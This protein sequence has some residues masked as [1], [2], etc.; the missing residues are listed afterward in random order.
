MNRIITI[1]SHKGGVGKTTTALNLAYAI[2]RFGFRTLLVDL[3]PESGTTIASNLRNFTSKGLIDLLL[4]TAVK[5]DV[6]AESNDKLLTV[7]GSGEILPAH[8]HAFEQAA[9]D[10]KLATL[11]KELGSDYQYTIIDAPAGVGGVVHAAL[12]ASQGAILTTNCSPISLKSIPSF[13]KLI[14]HIS[15]NGNPQLQLDGVLLSMVDTR[16]ATDMAIFEQIQAVIPFE[17]FFQTV[18]PYVESIAQ[19]S[20]EAVPVAMLPGAEEAAQLYT[21]LVSELYQRVNT[22]E[23]HGPAKLF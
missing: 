4:G 16:S 17:A 23:T 20:L 9:W 14:E 13:L 21:N 18:I 7:I 2:G 15:T 3:D 6:L 10:G 5:A 12:N 19:S 1:A 11:L 22:P 8:M